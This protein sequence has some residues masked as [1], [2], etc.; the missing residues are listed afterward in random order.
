MNGCLFSGWM[1]VLMVP[2]LTVLFTFLWLDES[3][4]IELDTS[5]AS[6]TVFDATLL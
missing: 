1:L 2:V 5:K 6:K 4:A 3:I